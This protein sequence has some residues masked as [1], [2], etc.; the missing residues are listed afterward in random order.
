M[1]KSLEDAAE[2]LDLPGDW[3][4]GGDVLESGQRI[5]QGRWAGCEDR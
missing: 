3:M 1:D 5:Q 2:S 4:G